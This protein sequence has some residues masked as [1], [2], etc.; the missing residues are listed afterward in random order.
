[1]CHID[2]TLSPCKCCRDSLGQVGK[3]FILA[4]DYV[5]RNVVPLQFNMAI[6]KDDLACPMN[7]NLLEPG[8]TTHC[9]HFSY[10]G[11]LTTPLCFFKLQSISKPDTNGVN[12][13]LIRNTQLFL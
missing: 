2:A 8:K 12:S 6:G 10:S 1:M 9:G 11:H 5:A 3:F 7:Y 13:D 4:N